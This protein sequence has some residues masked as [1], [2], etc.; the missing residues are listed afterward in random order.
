[1][2]NTHK[3]DVA[4]IIPTYNALKKH[5]GDKLA[6]D[7]CLDSINEQFNDNFKLQLIFIDDFSTDDT[8]NYTKEYFKDKNTEDISYVAMKEK[9]FGPGPGRDYGLEFVDARYV[10]FMDND[11]QYNGKDCLYDI[12]KYACESESD[13]VVAKMAGMNGFDVDDELQKRDSEVG[14]DLREINYIDSWFVNNKMFKYDFIMQHNIRSWALDFEDFKFWLLCCIQEPK[15]SFLA[16]KVYYYWVKTDDEHLSKDFNW[17]TKYDSIKGILDIVKDASPLIKSS[18]VESMFLRLR[19]IN[20]SLV[21]HS[22]RPVF[23]NRSNFFYKLSDALKETVDIESVNYMSEPAHLM[24]RVFT[25]FDYFEACE[26]Y[27]GVLFLLDRPNEIVLKNNVEVIDT[28]ENYYLDYLAFDRLKNDNLKIKIDFDRKNNVLVNYEGYTKF[29]KPVLMFATRNRTKRVMIDL[30]KTK[31]INLETV[32]DSFIDFDKEKEVIDI[33][34]VIEDE[35]AS[36][37]KMLEVDNKFKNV[38]F[39][40]KN[41]TITVYKNWMNAYSIVIK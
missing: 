8:V 16:D 30:E 27:K 14:L 24:Y 17:D 3:Y 22:K 19:S 12:F 32:L 1:M 31:K 29:D 10:T 9:G 7:I 26:K 28:L 20:N 34:Q 2:N 13:V 23:L 35:H 38:K 36:L 21:L 18:A 25:E 5:I 4:L 37:Y 33:L 11:D 6:Y 40:Y 41:K 15:I 39:K